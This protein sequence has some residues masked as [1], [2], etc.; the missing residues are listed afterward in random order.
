MASGNAVIP[1]VDPATLP[2]GSVITSSGRVSGAR[3]LGG[4]F[5]GAL[6]FTTNDLL[7][8]DNALTD[9]TRET[10]VRFNI[11]LGD[12][13]E[14]TGAG[15]DAVFPHT[16]EAERSV[17]IAV[18]PDQRAIEVRGGSA[19]SDRV[20]DRIAQL[21]VSAAVSAFADGNLIDGLVSAVRV[22]GAA[23]K[24]A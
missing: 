1:V 22:M 2:S 23:I 7:R 14:D 11:Y 8:I 6:P 18:S 19:V 12:L 15:A 13:G 3:P 10:R 21:G 4:E 16:P 17:L 5:P 9:A 20:T 24:Q